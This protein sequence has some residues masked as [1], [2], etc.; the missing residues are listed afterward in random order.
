MERQKFDKAERF[1]LYSLWLR[2]GF[3][4]SSAWAAERFGM[5]NGNVNREMKEL[6]R[7]LP[8]DCYDEAVNGGNMKIWHWLEDFYKDYPVYNHAV[9]LP[10]HE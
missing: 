10:T 8:I 6:S 3:H 5:R 1:A 4:I 7:I 9:R 2:Q